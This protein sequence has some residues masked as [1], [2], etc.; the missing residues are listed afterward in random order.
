VRWIRLIVGCVAGV[1]VLAACGEPDNRYVK[2]SSDGLYLRIPGSWATYD[3]DD[4]IE[5]QDEVTD[6]Q[7][8]A[9][10][11]ATWLMAFDAAPDPSID[12]VVAFVTEHPTGVAQIQQVSPQQR[13]ELSLKSLRNTLYPIDDLLEQDQASVDSYEELDLD[14]G[15]RGSRMIARL[16]AEDG[17]EVV[18]DQAAAVDADTTKIYIVALS[19]SADC[20]A[21]NEG[22]IDDVLDSL[23]LR[24]N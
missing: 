18:V 1:S 2:N 14:D 5:A 16:R 24:T 23:T 20:Y 17:E 21:D 19:C 11:A 9:F 12:N 7:A 3:E 10:K 6:S 8:E 13:D 22:T 4:W 15:F